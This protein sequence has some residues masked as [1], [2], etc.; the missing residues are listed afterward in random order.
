MLYKKL[1]KISLKSIILLVCIV[2]ISFLLIGSYSCAQ[3][4]QKYRIG[5]VVKTLTNPF[6]M[7]MQAAAI[8]KAKE[9]GID[10]MFQASTTEVDTEQFIRICED[11]I[12]KKVDGLI[13]VPG[14]PTE[15]AP[16]LNRAIK[17]GIPVMAV[18]T[19]CPDVPVITFLGVD[20][21][22]AA[23]QIA[24]YVYNL[25]QV[26]DDAKYAVLTGV[27]GY[28]TSVNRAKGYHVGLEKAFPKA[29]CVAELAADWDRE[30]G[31]KV[32]TDMITANKDIK[33]IFGSNDEMGLG[34]IEAIK[35]SG[36]EGNIFTTGFD[37][38]LDALIAV[39][40]GEMLCTL[41]QR[42]DDY[43]RIGVE[44]MVKYLNGERFPRFLRLETPLVTKDNVD[45][46][47][48]KA[49]YGY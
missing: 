40:K 6:Y 39:Q 37:A 4:T 23:G 22:Y 19:D 14:A 1:K 15:T 48:K 16:V 47:I 31:M 29:Q 5:F 10:L 18:E 7:K 13:V 38:I 26:P 46:F 24:Q 36:K 33:V 49:K 43:G 44:T 27:A 35:L 11:M 41:D 30:K 21:V 3:T 20:N 12:I 9:L 34:A 8:E 17:A 45:E 42:P 25:E 2:L 32:A 28:A